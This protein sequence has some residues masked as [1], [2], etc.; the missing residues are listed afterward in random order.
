[1]Q[2]D[3]TPIV[4]LPPVD[5]GV[6]SD[7]P[8]TLIPQPAWHIADNV[9]FDNGVV[10]MAS[11]WKRFGSGVADSAPT[12]I[13]R[14][15]LQTGEDIAVLGCNQHIYRINN[16]GTLTTLQSGLP[17]PTTYARWGY[18]SFPGLAFFNRSDGAL[19][20]YAYNGSL[21]APIPSHGTV[22]LSPGY[23]S[24]PTGRTIVQFANHLLIGA[25]TND[26]KGNADFQ[27]IAGSD[28]TSDTPPEGCFD[29]QWFD[30]TSEA[31]MFDIPDGGDDVL[32]MMRIGNQLAIFKE[33]SI[34]ALQ[35]VGINAGVYSRAQVIGYT[36]IVS[37]FACAGFGDR[38]FFMG[39]NN[40]YEFNGISATPIA[41]L[42]WQRIAT[43]V[44]AGAPDKVWAFTHVPASEIWFVGA[45]SRAAVYKVTTGAWAFR[46]FPFT[47]A[48]FV[49]IGLQPVTWEEA[50]YPWFSA[51]FP[52]RQSSAMMASVALLFASDD[53][54]LFIS[55]LP[56][57][58]DTN[59]LIALLE[60]GDMSFGGQHTLKFLN[61]MR[62]EGEVSGEEPLELYVGTRNSLD[63]PIQWH[64]PYEFHH[65]RTTF[66]HIARWFRF[67]FR[68]VGGNFSLSRYIPYVKLAG[69]R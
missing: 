56:G 39:A 35:Y 57:L 2:R 46:Y 27:S 62:V 69:Y 14:V 25:L 17:A 11:G 36:G 44:V 47:C 50:N 63:E 1:M 3:F 30:Q 45:N 59:P 34:H 64:G 7:V 37:P 23:S 18:D 52:W 40:V 41:S 61:E 48:G 16:N 42:T 8:P 6:V 4:D 5:K 28:L 20:V 49:N 67:R 22:Y 21:F 54:R 9:Q 13:S 66:R 65:N 10:K 43:D 38:I 51:Q 31:I 33:G 24:I 58:D 53:G 15:R 60:T 68:K 32:A 19:P 26:G 29:W 55:D 12:L